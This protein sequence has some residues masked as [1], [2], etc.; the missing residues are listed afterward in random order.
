MCKYA[1]KN[2]VI[3]YVKSSFSNEKGTKIGK[4]EY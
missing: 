2:G 4:A 3:I 1:M